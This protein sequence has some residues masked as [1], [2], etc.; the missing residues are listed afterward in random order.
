M[1]SQV[2][3]AGGQVIFF[4]D[5]PFLPQVMIDLAQNDLNNLDK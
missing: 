2:L 5:L 1:R 4:K 3:L